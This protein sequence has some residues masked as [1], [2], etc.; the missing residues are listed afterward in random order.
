[1]TSISFVSSKFLLKK[2]IFFKAVIWCSKNPY[3][4][5][6]APPGDKLC[7]RGT[8]IKKEIW[9]IGPFLGFSENP[10]ENFIGGPFIFVEEEIFR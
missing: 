8:A 7:R 9:F 10:I 3:K 6:E 4:V 1:M 5:M 2:G